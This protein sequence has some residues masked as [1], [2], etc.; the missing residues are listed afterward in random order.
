MNDWFILGIVALFLWGFWGFFPKL[1]TNYIDPKSI[2]IF[3][4]IAGAVFAVVILISTN[5]RTATHTKGI[6]FAFLSGLFG[7]M[8]SLLFLY[9]LSK[10]KASIVVAMTALYPLVT[11]LLAFL[12]LKEPITLKQGIGLF[13]ALIAILFLSI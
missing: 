10:G 6:T 2:L 7:S 5:F 4:S 11:I 13:L 12:I 3:Q 8:G 9:S 1:A